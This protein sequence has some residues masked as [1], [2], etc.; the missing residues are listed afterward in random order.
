MLLSVSAIAGG[1]QGSAIGGKT[2]TPSSCYDLLERGV[3]IIRLARLE[4]ARIANVMVV[5]L[6]T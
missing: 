4:R 6:A 3:D 1:G 2:L 5:A